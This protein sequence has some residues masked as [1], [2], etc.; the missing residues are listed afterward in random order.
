[1]AALKAVVPLAPKQESWVRRASD[2]S[3]V[4]FLAP[5]LV[6]LAVLSIA[7]TML[8]LYLSLTNLHLARPGTGEFVGFLNYSHMLTDDYFWMSIRVTLVLI[9]VPVTLQ[10]VLGLAMALLLH[11]ELPVMR[12]TRSI[13]IAPMVIPPI[14]A[15]LMWK[16]LYLPNLGGLNYLLGVLGLP[17]PDWFS[18][19]P[20][21]VLAI[22]IVAVW[23]DTPFV[24]LLL[25]AALESLPL[26]PFE[27][28]TVDGASWWQR[29]RFITLPLITP[30]LLIAAVFRVMGSLA[31]FPVIYVLTQ[32]GPGR[33]TEVLNFLAYEYGFR[34]LDIG[35]ASALSAALLILV[36]GLS[37]LFVRL[38]F[39]A[40]EVL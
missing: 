35:Y 36:V 17:G 32:G 19:G 21:A 29:F 15:G 4:W 5:A 26:E 27:A 22:V 30:V 31:I 38:R 9:A 2:R 33:S 8:T 40:T 28:A 11:N 37:L 3:L 24:M 7:P 13:F 6:V 14:V 25:L 10:M 20:M 16:V 23:E 1:M 12:A 34:F 39:R 18:S